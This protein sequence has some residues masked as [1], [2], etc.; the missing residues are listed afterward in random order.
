[1]A[2]KIKKIIKNQKGT[3]LLLAL[4]VM[5]SIVVAGIGLG[6]ILIN[7]LRQ[8]ILLDNSII[9]YYAAES[10]IESSLYK[11]RGLDIPLSSLPL[12]GTLDN[13]AEW[14][15]EYKNSRPDITTNI[16]ENKTYQ[17]DLFDPDDL[18]WMPGIEALK[19]SWEGPGQLEVAYTSWTPAPSIT[20]PQE[21]Y[22]VVTPAI[23]FMPPGII[24]NGIVGNKAYRIRLRAIGGDIYNLNI[25]GWADDAASPGNQV[26]LP[27]HIT[28]EANGSIGRARQAV[29]A[30]IPRHAQ[31]SGIFDFVLFSEEPIAKD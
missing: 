13:N 21:Q 3:V 11:I 6:Q 24:Y 29:S 28:L 26:D 25:T 4:L 22:E 27:S 15:L 1:M 14:T 2:D 10:A 18:S 17:L 30:S 7:Q 31:L 8:A 12:S 9:A 5:A 19:F 16:M 23:S 20:W